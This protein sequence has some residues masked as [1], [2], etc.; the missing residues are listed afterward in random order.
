MEVILSVN[1]AAILMLLVVQMVEFVLEATRS[2]STGHRVFTPFVGPPRATRNPV[3][4]PAVHYDR[5]A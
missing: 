1:A 5:A 3:A 2:V 4:E